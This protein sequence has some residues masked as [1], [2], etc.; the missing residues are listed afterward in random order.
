MSNNIPPPLIATSPPPFAGRALAIVLSVCLG[1]FLVDAFVSLANDSLMLFF[2]LQL[3]AGIQMIVSLLAMLLGLLVYVLMAVT[4]MIPKRLFLPVTLFN[5]AASLLFLPFVIYCFD[6]MWWVSWGVSAF[7]VAL[8]LWIL[9]LAQGG[10]KLRWPLVS[11]EWL[12]ARGFSW[13]NLCGFVLA[14]LL[15]LL[16]ATGLYLTLCAS[17]AVNHFSEGFMALR[18]SGFTVQMRKYA[19][20]DGKTVAL[21]PMAHVAD[22]SFYQTISQTFPTNS[23]ILLEG[24]TDEKHLLTNDISYHRMAKALGLSE[25]QVTFAPERGEKVR[26]DVD[27]SIFSTNTLAMLNLVMQIHAQGL[28]P[29]TLQ[30]LLL[31]PAPQD[32][33]AEVQDDLLR[34]RNQHL[35]G[36]LNARLAQTDYIVV[37]WGVAHMPGI[38]KQIVK[39]GFHLTETRN[40]VVIGFHRK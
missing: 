38:S 26:A 39:E 40:Y 22:A 8:A 23:I 20:D 37:P 30:K 18:P 19:R 33:M 14:N 5:L 31:Y 16:P 9:F 34:K 11:V 15:I 29:E 27:V 6:R 2:N 25:Q 35:M 28:H 10:W 7:Q 17:A 21:Y 32:L 3:L 12:G 36:E 4:P 1:L 13:L 24:V